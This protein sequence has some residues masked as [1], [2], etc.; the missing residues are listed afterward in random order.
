MAPPKV[1]GLDR[2]NRQLARMPAAAKT[3]LRKALDKSADEMVATARALAPVLEGDL[4]ASID[5][6]D[7]AHDLAVVVRAGGGAA[8]LAHIAEYGH[9]KAKPRPFFWPAYRALRKG[10]RSRLNRAVNTAA[11]KA[12]T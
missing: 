3:E 12:V 8:G 2:L 1:A 9:P 11:K 4:K 7:G 10:I 5:K 6:T